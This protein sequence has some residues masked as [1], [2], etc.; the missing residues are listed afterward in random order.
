MH[1]FAKT[2]LLFLAMLFASYTIA[3]AQIDLELSSSSD[4]PHLQDYS[5][6]NN[7]SEIQGFS[8]EDCIDRQF[9]FRTQKEIDD[10]AANYPN[11]TEVYTIKV[12]GENITNLQGL[13]QLKKAVYV[14]VDSTLVRNLDGLENIDSVS[15][16]VEIRNN[17][18][19]QE[20]NLSSLRYAESL[21]VV[22]NTI[23]SNL[24]GLEQLTHTGHLIIH[25]N[26]FLRTFKGLE[27]LER[28]DYLLVIWGNRYLFDV[29]AI[30]NADINNGILYVI[31]YNPL[32][33]VCQILPHLCELIA[34]NRDFFEISNNA[35][36]C[37]SAD[38]IITSCDEP[39]SLI[40]LE[41]SISTDNPDIAPG[42]RGKFILT[43]ENKGTI[44][45]TDVRITTFIDKGS[46][47]TSIS[48]LEIAVSTGTY[49]VN[50]G[51]GWELNIPAGRSETLEIELT[52]EVPNLA[53]FT[54]VLEAYQPDLDSTP[55][56]SSCRQPKEDD[57]AFFFSRNGMAA[58]DFTDIEVELSTPTADVGQFQAFPLEIKVH[59]KGTF[60]ATD[61]SVKLRECNTENSN[62]IRTD[63]PVVYA[64]TDF[65]ASTGTFEELHQ[66]W[67]IPRLEAGQSATLQV[68]LYSRTDDIFHLRAN[69]Y[70]YSYIE[71]DSDPCYDGDY[72][73]CNI[74]EDD[75]ASIAF[76]TGE[77]VAELPDLILQ[78]IESPL[79]FQAGDV[80]RFELEIANVGT[81]SVQGDFEVQFI[82][83]ED[84]RWDANDLVVGTIPTGN[85]GLGTFSS[86]A[87]VDIP[88]EIAAGNYFLIGFADAN[89]AIE[90]L[91]E[92][93]NQIALPVTI[94]NEAQ[95]VALE[96]T[97][98]S[99]PHQFPQPKGELSFDVRIQNPN[100]VPSLPKELGL[101]KAGLGFDYGDA[102]ARLGSFN[103]P[104]I[105]AN[106][107]RSF[108]ATYTYPYDEIYFLGDRPNIWIPQVSEGSYFFSL[109]PDGK[110]EDG[111]PNYDYPTD[112]FCQNTSTDIALDI[113]G[114]AKYGYMGSIDYTIRLFNNG[115][116]DAYNLR[117]LY[118]NNDGHDEYRILENNISDSYTTSLAAGPPEYNQ[119]WNVPYLAAG[120]S[121]ILKIGHLLTD[122]YPYGLQHVTAD[123]EVRILPD[124]FSI[125]T[126][127]VSPNLN[128]T[129][130]SNNSGT[131]T[132]YRNMN[133]PDLELSMTTD[134]SDIQQWEK[135]KFQFVIEN[136]GNIDIDSVVIAFRLLPEK[137]IIAGGTSPIMT[138][139][140][141]NVLREYNSLEYADY[142]EWE[143]ID[144][145]SGASDTLTLQLFSKVP[146]L[147]FLA[148]VKYALGRYTPDIDSY[149]NNRHPHEDD[150]VFFKAIPALP[151]LVLQ[152]IES[153]LVFPVGEVSR[154]GLEIANIGAKTV[155]GDFEIQFVLSNDEIL[156]DDDL[157]VGAIATGN[158][159][160]GVFRSTAAVD[161]S[162]VVAVGNY[163]LIATVD[164]NAQITESNE[165]NNQ[166]AIPI[167]VFE[168]MA[169]PT[170]GNRNSNKIFLA[171]NPSSD[172][173]QIHGLKNENST[174][175]IYD[176]YGKLVHNDSLHNK[177]IEVKH[178]PNGIYYL[179]LQEVKSPLRFIKM[180]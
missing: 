32:L 125:T 36:G 141:F 148:E 161:I 78:N 55:R 46:L 82:L 59:N 109:V 177:Q 5:N 47:A 80:S 28:V 52:S 11:C 103:I 142:S 116:V 21:Y 98:A 8:S 139:G 114:S 175:Q 138:D 85:L 167:T 84:G 130:P 49:D 73:N 75:E 178:L 170:G 99:C 164:A 22:N 151:D 131:Y 153:P 118:A 94:L 10:F 127:V 171:P 168:N 48:D 45:A 42:E 13:S 107:S 121:A 112:I 143:F 2:T 158:L 71:I 14:I 60:A 19:L 35:A 111:F 144:L 165:Q 27:N 63:S 119:Y 20:L 93:N 166:Q 83:S 159:G 169:A 128:D 100:D 6:V 51:I 88:F 31:R 97:Y 108:V 104:S 53:F 147:D 173:I 23:L 134:N 95:D 70:G 92:N 25:S 113:I 176:V 156:S 163:F 34:D 41:L 91:N 81:A 50:Y 110:N 56:N 115:P 16:H 69:A 72:R 7:H 4:T 68:H 152:N 62:F 96:I 64:N 67:R 174:F 38:E 26:R 57:E 33:S 17:S 180:E 157:P 74:D 172:I 30:K 12:A 105:P 39:C 58:N 1:S 24:K 132:A 77:R 135:G 155:Q 160:V 149:P 54:H 106:N 133:G 179:K 40:D 150:I 3:I 29:S 89:G 44:E 140:N 66:T 124:S 37:N 90:E 129:N 15:L 102:T 101:F 87:A 86:N 122:F 117:V 79:E 43:L 61:F 154:F 126:R 76:N 120:D 136:K 137:V 18:R 146:R 123:D 65:N 145:P 162:S 9:T